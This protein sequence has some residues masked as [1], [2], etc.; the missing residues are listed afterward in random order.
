MK[1]NVVDKQV[2][3]AHSTRASD[4]F[5]G[6]ESTTLF[7]THKLLK[8][9]AYTYLGEQTYLEA[10]MHGDTNQKIKP[11]CLGIEKV[12]KRQNQSKK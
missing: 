2:E 11:T 1:F 10:V 12:R 7:C 4:T 8:P 9:L 5:K 6:T 3:M